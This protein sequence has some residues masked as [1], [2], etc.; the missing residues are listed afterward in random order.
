MR[1]FIRWISIAAAV[2]AGLFCIKSFIGERQ[3]NY[4][5]INGV[6]ITDAQVVKSKALNSL[7]AITS[8]PD[9]VQK[10]ISN[11]ND[12]ELE[13]EQLHLLN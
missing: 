3:T 11:L 1:P 12:N 5:Y 10:S 8:T 6:K 7:L 2:F 9:E 13:Q 4:A